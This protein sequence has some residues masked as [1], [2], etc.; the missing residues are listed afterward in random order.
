M[1]LDLQGL[2]V[3]AGEDTA[4]VQESLAQCSLRQ[5]EGLVRAFSRVASSSSAS[6]LRVRCSETGCRRGLASAARTA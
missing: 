6:A 4:P 3:P 5:A 1:V 2:E